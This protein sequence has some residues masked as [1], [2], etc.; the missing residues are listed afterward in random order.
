MLALVALASNVTTMSQQS[1]E[2]DALLAV[3]STLSKLVNAGA[4]WGGLPILSGWLVHR[5][6][7]AAAAG[8]LAC[9]TA[10]FVH[11]GVGLLLGL[12]DSTVWAENQFWSGLAV[13]VGGPLGLVG[14]AARRQDSWGLLARLVVPLGAVLEPFYLRMLSTPEMMPWPGRVSSAV[15]GVL[16]IA[17]GTAGAVVVVIRHRRA[18]SRTA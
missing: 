12:F 1:A 15:A 7:P 18:R 8:I 2:A 16:L 5:P 3:R 17:A 6:M 4:V 13:V 14:A 11:Y 9:L 10:L